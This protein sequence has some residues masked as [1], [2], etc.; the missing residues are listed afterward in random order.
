MSSIIYQNL[1]NLITYIESFSFYLRKLKF[2]IKFQVEILD[3]QSIFLIN[4]Y[5]IQINRSPAEI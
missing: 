5:Q 1:M 4:T 3:L 2:E